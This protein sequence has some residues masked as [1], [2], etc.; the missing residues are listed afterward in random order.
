MRACLR[1]AIACDAT[2]GLNWL[3]A[4]PSQVYSA[5]NNRMVDA[6][7]P[8]FGD[9]CVVFSPDFVKPMTIVAPMDTYVHI[10][11]A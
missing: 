4:R 11:S 2:R 10:Q 9:V 5:F 1:F 7:N 8:H 6:G 3:D